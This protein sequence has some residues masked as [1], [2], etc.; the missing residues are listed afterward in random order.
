[1]AAHLNFEVWALNQFLHASAGRTPQSIAPLAICRRQ[2]GTGRVR[3][4]PRA[5]H[6]SAPTSTSSEPHIEKGSCRDTSGPPSRR[7]ARS[8][9]WNGSQGS[10]SPPMQ[11]C[12][13]APTP[14]SGGEQR[15]TLQMTNPPARVGGSDKVF[16]IM[17]K[18]TETPLPPVPSRL[19]AGQLDIT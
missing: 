14:S 19:H 5:K 11:P 16:G 1:M 2:P 17:N 15:K 4:P 8:A 6:V 12:A 18:T 9:P 13:H 3:I 10:I 7:E